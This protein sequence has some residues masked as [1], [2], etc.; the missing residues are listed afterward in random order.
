MGGLFRAKQRQS[1]LACRAGRGP[2]LDSKTPVNAAVA[3]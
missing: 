2:R 3:R 1:D